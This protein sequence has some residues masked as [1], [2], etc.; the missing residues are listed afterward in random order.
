M[1][2]KK[3]GLTPT[4]WQDLY[5]MAPQFS[6]SDSSY[7]DMQFRVV[8]SFFIMFGLPLLLIF[9]KEPLTNLV[10]KKGQS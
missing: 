4:L 6:A 9:L 10:N 2:S 1:M 8:Q 5:F 7:P 3:P